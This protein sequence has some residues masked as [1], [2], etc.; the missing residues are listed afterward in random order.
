MKEV[1]EVLAHALIAVI[2]AYVFTDP[3]WRF[4]KTNCIVRALAE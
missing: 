4:D 1:G 2:V 3:N